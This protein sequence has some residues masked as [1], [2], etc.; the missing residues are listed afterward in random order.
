LHNTI[1]HFKNSVLRNKKLLIDSIKA[2]NLPP[3]LK[4]LDSYACWRRLRMTREFISLDPR[5]A[6]LSRFA[7]DDKGTPFTRMTTCA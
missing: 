6:A 7:R 5:T 2:L 1:L 3:F 4:N